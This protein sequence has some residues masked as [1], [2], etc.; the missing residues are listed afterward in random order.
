MEQVAHFL[1]SITAVEKSE[2]SEQSEP[3]DD[4]KLPPR[5]N[6]IRRSSS[7]STIASSQEPAANHVLLFWYLEDDHKKVTNQMTDK[8]IER[9]LNVMIDPLLVGP[10]TGDARLE[11]HQ[12]RPPF[13]I[14]LMTLNVTKFAQRV[15]PLFGAIDDFTY[16]L[17]WKDPYLTVGVLL[18]ATL[19]ILHPYL[20]TAVPPFALIMIFL[21]PSYLKLYAPD[22]LFVDGKLTFQNPIPHD[23]R[24]L[25][26]F[27]LPKPVPQLSK[28][29]LMNFTD[30]QNL[31]VPYIR[32]YDALVSW[33]QHYF[34]FEDESLSCV[35]FL[36][37]WCIMLGNL[38]FLPILSPLV[39]RFA[40]LKLFLIIFIWVTTC[41]L[42][43][44]I[45]GM[46]LDKLDTEEARLSR[47][48]KTDLL[49]TKLMHAL[50]PEDA[51]SQ[52]EVIREVEVFELQRLSSKHIWKPIGF[53]NDFFALNNP[54]RSKKTDC[55]IEK[56][57][58]EAA[59]PVVPEE[60]VE[61]KVVFPGI[62]RKETLAE[63]KPPQYWNFADLEWHIDY[64]PMSWVLSNYIMDLV[65]IDSYEK[66]VYDYVD[67]DKSP[68]E[69][70]FRRR[71][72]VRSCQRESFTQRKVRETL[73]AATTTSSD[74]IGK[75]F[76]QLLT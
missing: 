33:G 60:E 4:M 7:S 23:G 55:C 37:L 38:L 9:V 1:E 75:T 28:E 52:P 5:L 76:N 70:T 41:A 50:E 72:W 47:L 68:D 11:I 16:M 26:K 43:P 6:K 39:F 29:F 46:L 10:Q 36:L 64:E 67:S 65:S 74:R 3:T 31:L 44:T 69:H 35:V 40:S 18:M 22:P 63:I 53:T 13:S 25:A 59:D 57:H 58:D 8:L 19:A 56:E 66:W 20:L 2:Q 61:E 73:L 49:E 51:N 34:L 21:V 24:P 32:L 62:L 17:S 71:R 48:N 45:R 30:T 27:E 42:H 12:T 54:L 15:S 14:N